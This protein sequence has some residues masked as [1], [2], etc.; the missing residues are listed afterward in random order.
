MLIKEPAFHVKK[1]AF[2]KMINIINEE[3]F[4]IQKMHKGLMNMTVVIS[5][6]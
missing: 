6:K 5:R 2:E 1:Q 3:G 4:E